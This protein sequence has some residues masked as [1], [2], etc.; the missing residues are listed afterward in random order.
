MVHG[1]KKVLK[2]DGRDYNGPPKIASTPVEG[3]GD[4]TLLS[5]N[6]ALFHLI[7][8]ISDKIRYSNKSRY[9]K[10]SGLSVV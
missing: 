3:F 7:F 9:F 4:Q 5:Y 8:S 1:I 2:T 6:L 10:F